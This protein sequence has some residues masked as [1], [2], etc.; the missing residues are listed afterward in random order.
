M[1]AEL[2]RDVPMTIAEIARK[3]LRDLDLANLVPKALAG[4][5]DLPPAL[6]RARLAPRGARGLASCSTVLRA[7]TD[8]ATDDG[9]RRGPPSAGHDLRDAH[10]RRGRRDG[11]A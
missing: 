5:A 3:N 6:R 1:D 2:Q 9:A 11:G 10:R 4:A 7:K 8:L